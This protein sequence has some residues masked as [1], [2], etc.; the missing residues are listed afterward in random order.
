[1]VHV[2]VAYLCTP[3]ENYPYSLQLDSEGNVQLYWSYN[4]THITFELHS[5]ASG[6]IGFGISPNGKMYPADMV[7]GWVKENKVFFAVRM[8]FSLF[9]FRYVVYVES[10]RDS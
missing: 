7:I 2:D 1:M 10:V 5:R 9:M 6:Y 3:T 8:S 4:D